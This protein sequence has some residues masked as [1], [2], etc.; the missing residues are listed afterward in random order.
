MHHGK[1]GLLICGAGALTG[2]S[3]LTL[4]GLGFV[5]NDWKDKNLWFN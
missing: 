5:I 4:T 2:S 3:K 1:A